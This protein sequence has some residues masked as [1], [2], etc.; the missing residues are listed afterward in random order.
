MPRSRGFDSRGR[1]SHYGVVRITRVTSNHNITGSSPVN[2]FPP[3]LGESI[4]KGVNG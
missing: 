3:F 1:L 4:G 2:G